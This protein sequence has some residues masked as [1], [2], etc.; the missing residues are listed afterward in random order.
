MVLRGEAFR[1]GGWLSRDTGGDLAGQQ[2]VYDSLAKYALLPLKAAGWELTLVVDV[3]FAVAK[4]D[5]Q[6]G[7]REEAVRA[8]C[9]VLGAS[10]VRV[11]APMCATQRQGWLATIEWATALEPDHAAILVLRNDMLLKTELK[12]PSPEVVAADAAVYVPWFHK[13]NYNTTDGPDRSSNGGR[14]A[15]DTL[16][17]IPAPRLRAFARFLSAVPYAPTW[18]Q[19]SLHELADPIDG[20]EGGNVRALDPVCRE[21]D[22][23][24]G[25]NPLYS[26]AG[27]HVSQYGR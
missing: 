25:W 18:T 22:S 24:K 1:T 12:L 20:I 3:S 9:A 8:S 15:A 7:L 5:A 2:A 4:D 16:M 27:R 17:L 21:S 10:H 14:R 11:N 23:A 19:F 6:L 13:S 26:L